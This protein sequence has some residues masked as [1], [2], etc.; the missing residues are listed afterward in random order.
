MENLKDTDQY[1][2]EYEGRKC[3]DMGTFYRELWKDRC[4]FAWGFI[5]LD[6]RD[7]DQRF[8]FRTWYSLSKYLLHNIFTFFVFQLT[9][10]CFLSSGKSIN[11]PFTKHLGFW[12]QYKKLVDIKVEERQALCLVTEEKL[13]NFLSRST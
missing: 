3:N 7:P 12:D 6:L 13:E 9:Y 4:F 1:F 8:I 2:S 11:K 5:K 10:L